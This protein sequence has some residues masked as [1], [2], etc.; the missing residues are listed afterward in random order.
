MNSLIVT[1]GLVTPAQLTVYSHN[2]EAAWQLTH[3]AKKYRNVSE[4]FSSYKTV[5]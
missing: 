5:F 2:G 1:S 4:K 3:F